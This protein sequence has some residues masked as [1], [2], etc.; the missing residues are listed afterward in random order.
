[1]YLSPHVDPTILPRVA[2]TD[3]ASGIEVICAWPVSGQYGA[4]TR[5]AF[6]ILIGLATFLAK[7]GKIRAAALA[8]VLVLPTIAGIHGIVLAAVHVDGRVS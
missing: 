1:M 6:Y 4:G 7:K 2:A 8:A 5:I 3:A